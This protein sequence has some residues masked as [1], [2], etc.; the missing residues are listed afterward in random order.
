MISTLKSL[1]RDHGQ[2]ILFSTHAPQH[3]LEAADHVLLMK[4]AGSYTYGPTG[5]VMTSQKLSDLYGVAIDKARFVDSDRFT[6]AP[7]FAV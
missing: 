7:R 4:D 5:D 2:T 3:G 6:F 1:N